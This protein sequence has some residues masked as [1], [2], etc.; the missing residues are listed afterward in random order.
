M[1]LFIAFILRI[2]RDEKARLLRRYVL[3]VALA[4]LECIGAAGKAAFGTL[5]WPRASRPNA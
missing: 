5:S 1:L 4:S 2:A 3:Y